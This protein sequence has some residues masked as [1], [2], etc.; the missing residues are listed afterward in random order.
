MITMATMDTINVRIAN[1]ILRLKNM[2]DERFVLLRRKTIFPMNVEYL[3]GD[4][5]ES[6][7]YLLDIRDA[8]KLLNK[9]DKE[10]KHLKLNEVK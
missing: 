1:T 2:A 6:D 10:N 3:I 7:N 9:I 5:D 4:N 8:V